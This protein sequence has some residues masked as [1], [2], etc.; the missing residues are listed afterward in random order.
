MP[1]PGYE[2][3]LR[4]ICAD[5]EDDTVR[6][7]Y[8]D[9][10]DENGDPDRAEFIRLQVAVPLRPKGPDDSSAREAILW[11]GNVSRWNQEVPTVKGIDWTWEY[12]RGFLFQISAVAGKWLL[13][14]RALL[15]ASAPI[16]SLVINDAGQ[17]TLEKVF[18]VPEIGQLSQLSL[19]NCRISPGFFRVVSACPQ[20]HNLRELRF[21]HRHGLPHRQSLT[22]AEARELAETPMLPRLEVVSTDGWISEDAERLLLRRFKTVRFGRWYRP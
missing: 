16:H 1:P 4:A 21:D 15:F 7:A 2:P 14:H 6:L 20:L 8:A 12:R 22:D 3:F 9:W 11:R 17:G 10:L 19:R 5:P 18:V 13:E